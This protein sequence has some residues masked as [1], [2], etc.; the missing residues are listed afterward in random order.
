[1]QHRSLSPR[2]LAYAKYRGQGFS[3]PQ[4]FREAGYVSDKA[5]AYRLE[6]RDDIQRAIEDYRKRRDELLSASEAV[7]IKA[8]DL[9]DV[10]ITQNF[11]L[12]TLLNALSQAR[13]LGD[14]KTVLAI[15]SKL[16]DMLAVKFDQSALTD[17]SQSTASLLAQL[18]AL[19]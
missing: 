17:S 5:N 12:E 18:E 9:S 14:P 4:A 3:P 11:V 16:A 1:M 8:E 10:T 6:N 15:T 2:H 13:A 19:K 7:Q